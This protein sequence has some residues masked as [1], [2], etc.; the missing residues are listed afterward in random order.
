MG[1]LRLALRSLGKAIHISPA[2]P[3][4]YAQ[5]AQI[6]LSLGRK[7]ASLEDWWRALSLTQPKTLGDW[8]QLVLIQ[9][10][11]LVLNP[12]PCTLHPTPCILTIKPFHLRLGRP[13]RAILELER[14]LDVFEGRGRAT[15]K[16]LLGRAQ[17]LSGDRLE[18]Y[19]LHPTGTLN[20]KVCTPHLTLHRTLCTYRGVRSA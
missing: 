18:P 17:W 8:R 4:L 13:Q 9:V 1:Q 11:Y 14:L 3:A 19:T 15:V 20:P 7:E 12:A 16:A 5:R 6:L 2:D 10:L